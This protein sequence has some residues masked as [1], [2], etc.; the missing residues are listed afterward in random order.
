[1]A[2]ESVTTTESLLPI[3]NLFIV[4]ASS[5]YGALLAGS[6]LSSA[7]WGVSSLQTWARAIIFVKYN[8]QIDRSWVDRFIYYVKWAEF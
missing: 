3:E 4:D 8:I 6:F 2:Y 1:M 7:I 5:S